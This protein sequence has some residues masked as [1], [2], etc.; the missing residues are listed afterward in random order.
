VPSRS[1]YIRYRDILDNIARI[2]LYVEGYDKDRFMA[3]ERTC[4]AVERCLA[5]ISEAAVK[6]GSQA[7]MA[8]PSI[9]WRNIRDLGNHLRHAYDGVDPHILWN[10]VHRDLDPLARACQRAITGEPVA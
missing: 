8:D 10:I 7:E 4:D 1:P 9:P 3:D 6:L 2:K 5:R